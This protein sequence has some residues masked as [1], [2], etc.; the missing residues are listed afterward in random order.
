[1][2]SS[3]SERL[4]DILEGGYDYELVSNPPPDNYICPICILLARDAQQASCCGKIFCRQC[5][6]KAARANLKCLRCHED[7]KRKY[8]PDTRAICDINQLKVYCK[9]KEEGCKWKGEL[10]HA[11]THHDSCPCRQVECPNQCTEAVRSMDLPRHLETQCPNRN[12]RCRHCKQVGK[13]AYFST[14]H[15]EDCPDLHIECPNNGCQKKT[16]RRDMDAHRHQCPKETISCEYA[17]LGC[18]HVCLREAMVDHNEKQMQGHLQLAMNELAIHR[19]LLDRQTGAPKRNVL[20]MTNFTNLKEKRKSWYSPPFYAFPGGYKMCL[21]VYAGGNGHGG[22]THISVYLS[23]MAGENDK[24]LGWPMRGIFSIELLNQKGDHNHRKD[25]VCFTQL[26]ANNYNSKVS[27]GL[28]VRCLGR[29]RFVEYQDLKRELV[30][31]QYLKDDTLY[32][33]VTMTKRMST[34]KPWLADAIPS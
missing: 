16:K 22:G 19:T 2:A 6:E 4:E 15:L 14:D 27:R 30:L 11:E 8:F 3:R 10:H 1:M 34:S 23:L 13:H 33:R 20:K 24:N 9:N 26:E 31:R 32:F 21:I 5:I 12:A 18:H 28:A 25:L 29:P 7:V 17:E